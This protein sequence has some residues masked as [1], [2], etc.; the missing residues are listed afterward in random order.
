MEGRRIT[1]IA[2]P[3]EVRAPRRLR[4]AGNAR[5][6]SPEGAAQGSYALGVG[7]EPTTGKIP[8][9]LTACCLQPIGHPRIEPRHGIEPRPLAYKASMQPPTLARHLEPSARIELALPHYECGVLPLNYEGVE[10]VAGIEP[11]LVFVGNEAR[12]R[13]ASPADL[14]SHLGATSRSRFIVRRPAPSGAFGAPPHVV[15]VARVERASRGPKPRPL[16]LGHTS[17]RFFVTNP[18]GERSLLHERSHRR[19]ASPRHH[20][21]PAAPDPRDREFMGRQPRR[22]RSAHS[23]RL[24]FRG[25][26]QRVWW[27][28]QFGVGRQGIEP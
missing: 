22:L 26:L 17:K 1:R 25:S 20:T 27:A 3:A 24:P 9:R 4:R 6:Q 21:V 18:R 7:F 10:R 2:T 15:E 23:S 5:R 13:A 12:H 8:G 11:S 19:L 14:P 28:S 16:P